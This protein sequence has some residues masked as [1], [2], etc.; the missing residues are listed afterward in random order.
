[1]KGCRL[2]KLK[3]QMYREMSRLVIKTNQKLIKFKKRRSFNKKQ[4]SLKKLKNLP[5]KSFNRKLSKTILKLHK[6]Q[7]KK[8]TKLLRKKK[9]IQRLLSHH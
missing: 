4:I 3:T 9:S 2:S 8:V 1:M 7:L 5:K 6:I